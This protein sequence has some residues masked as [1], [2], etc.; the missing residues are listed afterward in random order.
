VRAATARAKEILEQAG[1]RARVDVAY[2]NPAE[3]ILRYAADSQA[4]VIV[5]GRRGA[6]LAK[7]LLGSV[8][9]AVVREARQPVVVLE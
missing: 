9:D 7:T 1:V 6:G 3:E 8:S 5:I 2:G 4:A